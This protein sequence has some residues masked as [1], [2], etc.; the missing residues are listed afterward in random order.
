MYNSD[1]ARERLEHL[2]ENVDYSFNKIE[3]NSIVIE[4]YDFLT[5]PKGHYDE[6]ILSHYQQDDLQQAF[7]CLLKPY[8]HYQRILIVGLGNAHFNADAIGP[9][10]VSKMEVVEERLFLFIPRVKGQTG[11]ESAKLVKEIVSLYNID[12]VIVIDSLAAIHSDALYQTIQINTMG[13]QPGSGVNNFTIA[14]NE[15]YL[16]CK[17][18]A[19]GIPCVIK[20]SHLINEFFHYAEGFF[21]ESLTDHSSILKVQRHKTYQGKLDDQRKT[22][23]LGQIGMLNREERYQLIEEIMEPIHKNYVITGKDI[24]YRVEVL[25]NMISICLMNVFK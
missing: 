18:L 9:R 22:F 8:Q 5:D 2:K 1:L 4:Q 7:N 11:M 20:V 13:L 21:K 23:L 25:S 24:D 6:L 19:I 12:F 16:G 14:I 17:V 15:E 10:I 3:I